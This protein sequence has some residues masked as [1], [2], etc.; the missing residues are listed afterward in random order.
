MIPGEVLTYDDGHRPVCPCRWV[1]SM[2]PLGY[3]DTA[4]AILAA[5]Q[6][7]NHTTPQGA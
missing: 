4:R 6:T 1:G 3:L 7:V 5:H 2:Y